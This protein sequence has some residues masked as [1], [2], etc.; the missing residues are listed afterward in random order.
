[1]PLAT[2]LYHRDLWKFPLPYLIDNPGDKGVFDPDT[3]TIHFDTPNPN[4]ASLLPRRYM[5]PRIAEDVILDNVIGFDVKA[6]DVKAPLLQP[7]GQAVVLA[8]G[9]PGYPKLL[10][11]YTEAQAREL[12]KILNGNDPDWILVGKGAYV[13]LHYT[14]AWPSDFATA[15]SSYC[16]FKTLASLVSGN[17]Y[18]TWSTH[19]EY[20]GV[21]QDPD[22][23]HGH[24][25][26]VDSGTNG[27]D[28]EEDVGDPGADTDGDGIRHDL[29][30]V[31]DDPGELEAPPPYSVPLRGI[32]V[33]IRVFEPDSRQVREVTIIQDFLPQ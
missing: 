28:D 20:D 4:P 7:V 15:F 25:S 18:D 27:F 9:D 16:V 17:F 31:V 33:K 22:T 29:D 26:V 14:Q 11:D 3:G 24:H 19:Y 6:W 2:S 12:A 1:M 21:D 10:M 23:W 32:Q 30:G 8:P 13:D 5:G